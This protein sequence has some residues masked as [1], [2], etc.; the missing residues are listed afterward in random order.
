[1][2]QI[3]ALRDSMTWF[4]TTI[5]LLL[6]WLMYFMFV[7]GTTGYF[8]EEI[9]S[10]MTP[11]IPHHLEATPQQRLQTLYDFGLAHGMASEEWFMNPEYQRGS[12]VSRIFYR[13]T[14][15]ENPDKMISENVEL[16]SLTGEKVNDVARET[17]GGY[18][19]YRMHWRLHYVDR[20]IAYYFIGVVTLFMFIGVVTGIIIHRKIFIDFF[21]FRPQANGKGWLD[22]HNLVSVTSLPFQL[23][24]S[25]SG[26][27]FMVT[28]FLPM[29]AFGSYN[30]D[31]KNTTEV[32]T[33]ALTVD[34]S[35]ERSGEPAPLL[36]PEKLLAS[37]AEHVQLDDIHGI[38]LQHPGDANATAVVRVY[39]GFNGA[40]SATKLRFNAVTGEYI[41]TLPRA[42]NSAM[43]FNSVTLD[44][45]EGLFSSTDLR[46]LYFVAGT[47]GCIMMASGSIYYVRK[48]RVKIKRGAPVPRSL[49]NIEATNVAVVLGLLTGISAFFIANRLLPVGMEDRADWEMHCLFLTWL[50]CFIHAYCRSNDQAWFEQLLFVGIGYLL[51][52]VVSFYTV[53][54]HLFRAIADGNWVFAGTELFALALSAVS[55]YIAYRLRQNAKHITKHSAKPATK[56]NTRADN[57]CA[58]DA[59]GAT[60]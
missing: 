47:L 33:K 4:H 46:W 7:T 3:N 12:V 32:L 40:R 14:D 50:G 8:D 48:R 59:V 51:L 58:K 49:R 52:P 24:I 38:V 26:L 6:C 45:H 10:Y 16:N 21:T 18:T 15:P 30:F 17:A 28:T 60:S 37:I 19:L 34:Q 56:K 36:A 43:L 29:I 5:G 55:F 54:Q 22:F 2:S 31:V 11:E 44:L 53:E 23:M 27:L 42:V 13:T 1:M 41:D 39:D 9:D 25:Y 57:Q 35:V 20:D